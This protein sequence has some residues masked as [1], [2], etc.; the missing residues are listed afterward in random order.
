MSTGRGGALRALLTFGMV[1]VVALQAGAQQTPGAAWSFQLVGVRSVTLGDGELARLLGARRMDATLAAK[2][3]DRTYSG[4]PL[5]WVAALVDD[6]ADATGT[7]LDRELWDLGYDVTVTARDGY[8]ATFSTKGLAPEAVLLVDREGGKS[9]VPSVVGAIDRSLWVKDVV[10]IELSI[11]GAAVPDAVSAASSD[12]GTSAGPLPDF[13]LTLDLNGTEHRFTIA[14]LQRS[15]LYLEAPGSFTTSAGSR[16]VGTYGGVRLA[17]L[18]GQYVTLK[19]TESVVF[20]ATDG[21]RMAYAAADVLDTSRGVWILAFRLDGAYLPQDPG[22][23]RTIKVGP[24]TPNIDGHL[25]VKMVERVELRQSGYR[26]FELAIDGAMQARVD[27]QT[28]QSCVNC[29]GVSVSYERKGQAA[30]Y[31][32]VA[33]WRFLAYADDPERAPHRAD[34]SVIAYDAEAARRGYTVEVVA[35]D[36]FANVLDSRA[37]HLNDGIILATE[38]DGAELPDAEWPLVL[39]WD[40]AATVPEAIKP[41]RQVLKVLL[42][43]RAR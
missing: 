30:T 22:Y 8:T 14:E 1:V 33:L 2:G 36:G 42:G 27:R 9:I 10:S 26:S 12:E 21:Y 43:T 31:R 6:A 17:S 28:V 4:Y 34:S 37:L 40:K 29:H 15:P 25:S 24:D 35:A 23:I 5:G 18:I 32:G 38:K 20:V 13:T 19:P 3:G 41:V 39:A 7:K 16:Y 11:K